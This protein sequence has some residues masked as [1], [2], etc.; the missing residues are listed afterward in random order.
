MLH[1]PESIR[2]DL[3]K[4]LEKLTSKGNPSDKGGFQEELKAIRKA[5]EKETLKIAEGFRLY[6]QTVNEYYLKFPPF[7]TG[8]VNKDFEDFIELVGHSVIIGN[9]FLLSEWGVKYPLNQPSVLAGKQL[10][11]RYVDG[12]KKAITEKWE[13]NKTQHGWPDEAQEYWQYLIR[14]WENRL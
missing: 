9:Y 7:G 4:M 12:F 8:D 3:R 14:E 13:E 2:I 10:L 6:S 1:F 11:S 5:M